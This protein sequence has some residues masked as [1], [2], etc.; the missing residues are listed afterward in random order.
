MPRS[1]AYSNVYYVCY[2]YIDAYNTNRDSSLLL[3]S[4]ILFILNII[5]FVQMTIFFRSI[6]FENLVIFNGILISSITAAAILTK[7][8]F[9]LEINFGLHIVVLSYIIRR[10]LHLS[11]SLMKRTL[12]PNLGRKMYALNYDLIFQIV[13]FS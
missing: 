10:F 9:I 12:F 1:N 5:T 4:W 2:N 3:I 7:Y 13:C 11:T 8:E 6:K